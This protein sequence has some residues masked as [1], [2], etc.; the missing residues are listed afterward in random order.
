MTEAEWLGEVSLRKRL[1]WLRGRVRARKIRLFAIAC[2]RRIWGRLA[3]AERRAV[4]AAEQ[5]LERKISAKELADRV[6]HVRGVAHGAQAAHHAC[7]RTADIVTGATLAAIHARI[8]AHWPGGPPKGQ[9]LDTESTP[10]AGAQLALLR[11]VVGNPFRPVTL[12]P[13]CQTPDVLRLAEAVYA[14][15]AFERLPVLADALEEVG[16]TDAALL[17]HLRGPGPHV[18]GCF[19]LDAVLARAAGTHSWA[20]RSARTAARRGGGRPAEKGLP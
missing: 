17:G 6:A 5:F 18:L 4:E 7:A 10:E 13:A 1:S 9:L 14:E 20:A 11:D 3:A 16:C 2:C 12:A 19:A 15:R 8:V